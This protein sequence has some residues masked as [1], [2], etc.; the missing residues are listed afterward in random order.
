MTALARALIE[1][2]LPGT[3]WAFALDSA[4]RRAGAC[5]WDRRR[6]TVSRYLATEASADEV[7]QVLLHE[8]AH[9]LA[10][11]SAAHGLEWRRA[12]RRIGYTGSR[13]H[14]RAFAEDRATWIG[15]CPAGPEHRRFRRPSPPQ[16]CARCSSRFT[17]TALITWRRAA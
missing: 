10:G 13:L 7:E 8:I 9:A 12:A 16:S 2:H 3:G 11:H 15:S 1:R 14:D 4:K 6:V 17:P 5:D